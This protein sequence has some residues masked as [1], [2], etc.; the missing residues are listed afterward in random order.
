MVATIQLVKG[1]LIATADKVHQLFIKTFIVLEIFHEFQ[2]FGEQIVIKRQVIKVS[3]KQLLSVVQVSK[4]PDHKVRVLDQY[5]AHHFNIILE[6][7]ENV[8]EYLLSTVDFFVPDLKLNHP[9]VD[10]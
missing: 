8:I 6:H 3:F 9:F 7:N 5:I 10:F 2:V 4:V 1:L